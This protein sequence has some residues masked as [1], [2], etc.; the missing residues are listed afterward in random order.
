MA[1][2]LA[3]H[4]EYGHATLHLGTI[5][6]SVSQGLVT[7][8]HIVRQVQKEEIQKNLG[9]GP[10]TPRRAKRAHSELHDL[11]VAEQMTAS[12]KQQHDHF[13]GAVTKLLEQQE[14]KR[15]EEQEARRAKKAKQQEAAQLKQDKVL[16]TMLQLVMNQAADHELLRT[17]VTSQSSLACPSR[18]ISLAQAEEVVQ[19]HKT[20]QR[21]ARPL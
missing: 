5:R 14:A 18:N 20:Y 15:A 9:Q 19:M 6:Y 17:L 4:S 8:Q 13:L 10:V 1:N 2:H 12:Q 16:D 11:K 7:F 21:N 3:G